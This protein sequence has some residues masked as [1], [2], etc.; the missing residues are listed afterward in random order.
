MIDDV[1]LTQ[2]ETAFRAEV[3]A[4]LAQNAAEYRD[5][6][7]WPEKEL[8]AR[9]LA[10]QQRKA[11]AGYGALAASV[12]VG[13]RD[14]QRLAAIFMEEE[15][16]YYTPTFTGLG[17]GFGM[18]L[19]TILRHGTPEQYERYAKP[20]IAG[21]HGWCQL[22]SEPSAGSDLAGLRTRAVRSGDN[23]I[24][25][26]QKVWSSWAHHADFG[27]LLARTNPNVVKHQGLTFFILDMKSPGVEVRPIRQISGK[28]DFNE[29]FLTDVVI[30]DAN[31]IGAEGEGWACAMTV[32]M[33]ERQGSSGASPRLRHDEVRSMIRTALNTARGAGTALDS[34]SVRARLAQWWIEEQGLKHLGQRVME[35]TKKG[36]PPS[37]IA[38]MMKLVSATKLQQTNAFLM[39]LGEYGG[40]FSEPDRPG[41]E[42]VFDQ[43]LWS[44]AMRIAGGADE[45]LRNQ[46]AERVLGMP[47][48]PRMDKVPFNQLP[49]IKSGSS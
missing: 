9:S 42:E 15:S 16:R 7:E 13:G 35:A 46:L 31:R 39:D 20:T 11:Q 30:P 1:T 5:S 34:A 38:A 44:S 10:W 27:I 21:K 45:I 6:V 19:P 24:V 43:Y 33:N 28:S 37:P 32:L 47:S 4:W 3:R 41:Q 29:T 36:E 40:L 23:W 12:A 25:N 17:I 22:F 14:S 49:G 2:E 8:V 18:A 48:E 26:G